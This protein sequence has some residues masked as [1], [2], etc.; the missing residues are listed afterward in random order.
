MDRINWGFYTLLSA[1]MGSARRC[2]LAFRI[3]TLCPSRIRMG[4]GRVYTS[5]L[6]LSTCSPTLNSH[7]L[8]PRFDTLIHHP[9]LLSRPNVSSGPANPPPKYPDTD[10]ELHLLLEVKRATAPAT[11][12]VSCANTT[13]SKRTSFVLFRSRNAENAEYAWCT[14]LL[15]WWMSDVCLPPGA[16]AWAVNCA[17]GRAQRGRV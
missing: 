15:L 16:I 7:H 6:S 17:C 1:V 13:K 10:Y 5:S 12:K 9:S 4:L 14:S 3:R 8:P 2:I 11:Q